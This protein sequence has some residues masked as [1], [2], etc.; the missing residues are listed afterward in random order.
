MRIFL[1]LLVSLAA[2]AGYYFFYYPPTLLKNATKGAITQFADAVNSKDRSRVG[3]SLQTLLSD[4]AQIKLEVHFMALVGQNRPMLTQQFDKPGFISFIDNTLYPL[5]DYGYRRSQ[6]TEFILADDQRSAQVTFTSNG[7]ADGN[8][9]YGGIAVMT[10]FSVETECKGT[11]IFG[12]AT[13]Q[14][15]NATCIAEFR[16]VPK[17]GEA[18]KINNMEG[19]KDRLLQQK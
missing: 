17:P 5:T 10:R 19:L 9:Y 6:L 3:A 15:Q 16:S 4:N 2:G 1:L 11:A 8:S 7:W 14:L 18:Q 12:A 13:P